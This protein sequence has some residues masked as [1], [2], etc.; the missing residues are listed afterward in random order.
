MSSIG[1]KRK[2]GYYS[3]RL[4]NPIEW[5][6]PIPHLP[7]A[8]PNSWSPGVKAVWPELVKAV[9]DESEIARISSNTAH[10]ERLWALCDHFGIDRSHVGWPRDLAL[11]LASRH[12]PSFRNGR[13]IAYA[14][15]FTQYSIDPQEPDADLTLAFRLAHKYVPG[16]RLKAPTRP[17]ARL[18]AVEWVYVTLAVFKIRRHLER[19]N[20]KASDRQV[21][22]LLMDPKWLGSIV[23]PVVA[24]RITSAL[25]ASGNKRRGTPERLSK[26]ALRYYLHDMRSAGQCTN[27]FQRFLM[28]DVFPLLHL[29]FFGDC[30]EGGGQT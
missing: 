26:R 11:N 13:H 30:A 29:T 4:A 21:V 12:E 19:E 20:K 14:H 2:R 22:E 9:E 7:P 24:G 8:A 27:E 28:E 5:Q 23:P 6:P 10:F 1:K 3:D 18:E 25:D 16:M 17:K 15:L